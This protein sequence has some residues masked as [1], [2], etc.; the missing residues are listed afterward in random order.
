MTEFAGMMSGQSPEPTPPAESVVCPIAGCGKRT[1]PE[2]VIEFTIDGVEDV[3]RATICRECHHK[4]GHGVI[5]GL[6][7]A[8]TF[9]PARND[10]RDDA[11]S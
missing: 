3:V 5:S 9:T 1:N 11:A 2:C 7:L 6:S 8:P 4:V 10:G